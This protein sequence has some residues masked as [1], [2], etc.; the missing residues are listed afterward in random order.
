MHQRYGDRVAFLAIYVREA[1]PTNGWRMESNDKVGISI[2]QPVSKSDRLAVAKQC[3]STLELTMPLLVDEINDR[4]GHAYSGMPDRMFL[5]DQEGRVAYKSGRGSF[6]FLPGEL[7]QALVISLLEKD[8]L[9]RNK[10]SIPIFENPEAW[11]CLPPAEK[12][13]GHALPTWARVLARTLPRTTAAM[14]ELDY[15]H[16]AKSPLDPKLRGKMRWV[17]AHTNHCKY[18]EAYAVADLRRA[19]VSDADIANLAGDFASLPMPEQMALAFARKLTQAADTVSDAEVAQLIQHYG[20]KQVVAMVLLLAY[21]NFQDRLLLALHCPL[22]AEGPLPPLEIHFSKKEAENGGPTPMVR[23]T[24]QANPAASLEHFT[25]PEWQELD[26]NRLQQTMEA[27]RARSPRIPVPRWEEVRQHVPAGYP[28]DKPL[29][30]RWSLVCLGYQTELSAAWSAC[31]RS[32][33]QESGQDRVFE[34][35]LFWVI[36][37]SLR[38]FY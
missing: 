15:L 14:L 24:P 6:G 23:K 5:I 38:C 18:A 2:V 10:K 33:A 22:E 1:H 25:D 12:G 37:R 7:E 20:Q 19:G 26:Y 3:C 21:A 36:T 30:I 27:Q 35:S 13:M 32:F 17:A 29:R 11:K 31:T 16:R 9:A 4:V 28:I 8:S 34:E